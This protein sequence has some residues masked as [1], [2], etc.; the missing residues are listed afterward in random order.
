VA[1]AGHAVWLGQRRK[2]GAPPKARNWA[3]ERKADQSRLRSELAREQLLGRV[4]RD[5]DSLPAAPAGGPASP[6]ATGA[7]VGGGGRQQGPEAAL[8]HGWTAGELPGGVYAAPEALTA[9]MSGRGHGRQPA[10]ADRPKIRRQRQGHRR[11][12]RTGLAR[13]DPP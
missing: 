7:P 12:G 5:P 13:G 9:R 6:P 2:P 1:R 4:A 11:G 3:L 10:V 8:P